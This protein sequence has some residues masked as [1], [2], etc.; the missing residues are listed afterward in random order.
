MFH[1][2][3]ELI[4]G[5]QRIPWLIWIQLVV[6]LLL[7]IL[8]HYLTIF[9]FGLDLSSGAVAA[10]AALPSGGQSFTICG[11]S[12]TVAAAPPKSEEGVSCSSSNLGASTSRRRARREDTQEREGSCAEK[13]TTHA[14]VLER[15][16]YHPCHYLGLAKQAFLKCLGLDPSSKDS[17]N[18][19]Q[20]RQE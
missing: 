19:R 10:T 13:D 18:T 16:S 5:G 9:A 12:N 14:S 6:M 3:D 17:I 11:P 1:F 8:L 20:R 7:I 15:S 2:G 4:L